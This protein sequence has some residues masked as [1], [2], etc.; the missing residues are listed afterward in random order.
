M[1]FLREC[2]M[3]CHPKIACKD[4]QIRMYYA[5]SPFLEAGSLV[6]EFDLWLCVVCL[7][8]TCSWAW[9]VV[10][11]LAC[12]VWLTSCSYWVCLSGCIFGMLFDLCCVR[13]VCCWQTIRHEGFFALYKGFIPLYLRLGPWNIIVSSQCVCSQSMSRTVGRCVCV[14]LFCQCICLCMCVCTCVCGCMC[15]GMPQTYASCGIAITKN[16][17]FSQVRLWWWAGA[18]Y[19]KVIR[20]G[21][22][23]RG[24]NNKVGKNEFFFV[25]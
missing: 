6:V 14:C 12:L 20:A 19:S 4:E 17:N 2:F 23:E 7:L 24:S 9:L 16:N 1:L 21:P 13:H 22:W 18:C 25:A 10:V 5:K 11:C 3:L 8:F 15:V